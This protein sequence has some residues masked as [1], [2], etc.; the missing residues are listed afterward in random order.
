M[1]TKKIIF[2][3]LLLVLLPATVF[4]WNDCHFGKVNCTYPGDCNR[5]IDTDNDG[6]C[7]YSQ[8]APE[9]RINNATDNLTTDNL[10]NKTN[11]TNTSAK[12]EMPGITE[13]PAERPAAKETYHL[14]PVSLLS[15]LLYFI[16]YILSKKNVISIATHRKIWNI[17]LL[18]TFFI[19]GLSGILLIIKIDFGTMIPLP[20]DILFWHVEAGIAMVVIS[21][22]HIL[23]HWQY[24]K[25]ALK[26]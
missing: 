1:V 9:N 4:A 8:P 5:Y 17:L 12:S 11:K 13:K 7:D 25:N 3:L 19:S 20:F 2:A 23:W 22:F 14:L 15:I 24:F 16:S 10:T 21:I 18:V 6:I 26:I